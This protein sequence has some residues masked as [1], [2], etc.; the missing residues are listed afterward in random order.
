M[1]TTVVL[2]M[3]ISA[4]SCEWPNSCSISQRI[5]ASRALRKRAPSLAFAADT[6]TS[7]RM[8]HVIWMLPLRK[9]GWLWTGRLPRKKYPPAQLR[10]LPVDKY[11]ASE[12][13]LRIM[14][15]VRNFMTASG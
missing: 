12:C 13:T 7:F 4:G 3:W 8:L 11:D 9:I 2:Y 10:A 5:F 14:L 15:E 6:S 1:P